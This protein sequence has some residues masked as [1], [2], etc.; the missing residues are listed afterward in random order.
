MSGPDSAREA[1]NEP[2]YGAIASLSDQLPSMTRMEA[3][4]AVAQRTAF[5]SQ[6]V[7]P[8]SLPSRIQ[9]AQRIPCKIVSKNFNKDSTRYDIEFVALNS[10]KGS[11]EHIRSDRNDSALGAIVDELWKDIE[12]GCFAVIYKLNDAPRNGDRNAAP[13]GYRVAP[14]VELLGPAKGDGR[15]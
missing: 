4:I 2:I 7:S 13:H 12:P 5:V 14:Y 10:D 8:S 9:R 15:R 11:I 3:E 1:D 6:M